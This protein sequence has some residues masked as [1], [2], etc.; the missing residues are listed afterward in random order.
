MASPCF[1]VLG[2]AASGKSAFAERLVLQSGFPPVYIATAQA[3]DDEMRDKIARHVAARGSRWDTIEAPVDLPGALAGVAP[4]RAVLVDCLTLWLTNLLLTETDPEAAT[5]D[6]LAALDAAPGPVTLV[7]NEVGQG[8]VPDNSLSRRFREAQGRL[9]I[10]MAQRADCVVQVVAGLPN[11]L[12][13]QL[14]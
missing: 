8:I 14:P 6:L 11:P 5:D 1:F 13:G 10:R 7:S 2:G 3:F 9:N 12:K 4:G